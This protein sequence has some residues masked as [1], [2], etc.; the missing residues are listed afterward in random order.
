[1]SLCDGYVFVMVGVGVGVGVVCNT[2]SR[3]LS[4]ID[5]GGYVSGLESLGVGMP[6]D[7]GGVSDDQLGSLGMR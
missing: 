2:Q 3:F 1:M 6:Q 7:I 5:L 4:G